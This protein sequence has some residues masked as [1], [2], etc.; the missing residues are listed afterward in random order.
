MACFFWPDGKPEVIKWFTINIVLLMILFAAS[1]KSAAEENIEPI[2]L[3]KIVVTSQ[4]KPVKSRELTRC[5]AVMDS[6]QIAALP[7]TSPAEA[8]GYLEGVDVKRRGPCGV[9]SDI[10]IRGSSFEQVL[11]LIDGVRMNDPQT[12]HHNMDLP[13]PM[14]SIER[15]EVLRGGGSCVYGAGAFGGVVNIITKTPKKEGIKVG[16][17]GGEHDL[18]SQSFTAAKFFKDSANMLSYER[19][20]SSGYRPDTDFENQT[21][22]FKSVLNEDSF[23]VEFKAG[24]AKKDFGAADFYSNLYPHEEEHTDTRF[25]NLKTEVNKEPFKITPLVFYRRHGDKFILDRNRPW[26][27]VNF[28][29]TYVYGGEIQAETTLFDDPLMFGIDGR[30]EKITSTN[31]G[32]H[33]RYNTALFF[34]YD[35]KIKDK[36]VLNV[37]L[38]ED[39]FQGWGWQ[40]APSFSGNYFLRDDLKAR[41]A[42]NSLYRI[43][44]YTEL[45]YNTSANKGNENLVPEKGWSCEAGC[46]YNKD[47]FDLSTTV[48]FR[49]EK[50]AIDWARNTTLDVWQAENVNRLKTQGVEIDMVL[51]PLYLKEKFLTDAVVC[52]YSYIYASYSALAPFTKY[53]PAYLKHCAYT[54]VDLSL[55]F[56]IKQ[57]LRL[58]YKE[59]ATQRHYF[60]LDSKIS[61]TIEKGS[62]D[63]EFFI[64]G[65]NLFNTSYS[66]ITDV[67]MPGRWVEA[68]LSLRL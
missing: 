3:E 57:T 23:P 39:Y 31:L 5:V 45:F 42:V 4:K 20:E 41:A 21:V 13:I 50:N 16:L 22:Y 29:T 18:F 67:V 12:A 25:F 2:Q 53:A 14:D 19:K 48:F 68:G 35:K 61:K 10:S 63:I 38:R 66:D 44:S 36:G 6:G 56:G 64:N 43:P 26:W 7:V 1:V 54:G 32:N 34:M 11:I 65:T 40:T 49:D 52:G 37:G 24:Y 51:K 60:L 46:D 27:Q 62:F 28:H 17:S 33:A 58:N 9:Q 15:I 8:L 30:E 47:N 59:R 55:P